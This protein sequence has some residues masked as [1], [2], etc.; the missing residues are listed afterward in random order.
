MESD[1]TLEPKRI[2]C[3]EDHADTC[4]LYRVILQM[5]GYA[6]EAVEDMPTATDRIQQ[7]TYA[8]IM[9]DNALAEGGSGLALCRQIRQADADTPVLFISGQA[10][11]HEQAEALAAGANAYLTK[12]V[13]PSTLI[14]AVRQLLPAGQGLQG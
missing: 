7:Q 14:S 11:P 3:V 5:E 6:F 12:P 2:L 13:D 4:N 8:L 10:Y 9:L 1:H